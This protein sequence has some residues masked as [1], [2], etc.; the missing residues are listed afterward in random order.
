MIAKLDPSLA[1][2]RIKYFLGISLLSLFLDQWTKIWA[3]ESVKDHPSSHF[4]GL[5]TLVYAENSG[6][7]GNLGASWP[8]PLRDL[9]LLY[10]PTIILLGIAIY[11]LIGKGIRFYEMIALSFIF[12]GGIGNIIDRFRYDYVVDFMYIG[13]QGIGTN[14]FNVADVSIMTGFFILILDSFLKKKEEKQNNP[15]QTQ[16]PQ[17]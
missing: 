13:W 7:W 9:F 10:L 8:D 6:A 16:A 3:M 15:S 14:I 4:F 2:K 12:S 11:S 17:K 1:I 5:F